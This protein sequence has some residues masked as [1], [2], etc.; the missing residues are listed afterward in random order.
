MKRVGLIGCGTIGTALAQ[1]L[2]RDYHTQ[3]RIVAIADRQRTAALALQRQLGSH[4]AIVSLPDLIRRS[5]LVL[6]AAAVSIAARV[7]RLALTTHRDVLIMSSGGLLASS[8]WQQAARRSHGHLYVPSGGLGGIDGVKALAVGAIRRIRLT[9]RKPPRALMTAPLVQRRRLRLTRLTRPTTIFDGSPQQAIREFPQNTN[10]AATMTL[11]CL[12][13][14]HRAVNARVRIVADP[15]ITRNIHEL[16][17][18]GDCGRLHCQIESRPSSANPK[19]SEVAVRSA[20]A[21][22]DQ[23]F[24]PVHIGT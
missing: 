9:T 21:T 6:E 13:S 24:N 22:L 16:D 4:P 7:A 23:L 11:A 8:A 3:A 17:V 2:E 12:A 15:T 20:L 5:Q 14:R 19:T 18:E 1:A 10:V